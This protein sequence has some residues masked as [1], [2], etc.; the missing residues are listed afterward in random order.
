MRAQ[1]VRDP[2]LLQ[3][4]ARP[5]ELLIARC[6]QVEATDDSISDP[7]N[8]VL[9]PFSHGVATFCATSK[10]DLK[11]RLAPQFLKTNCGC[12]RVDRCVGDVAMPQ[13]VLKK[14]GVLPFVCQ[15]VP[16]TVPE[17]MRVNFDA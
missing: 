10:N 13:I 7:V 1:K 9:L 17:H 15:G 3:L 2:K 14:A 16:A 11:G 12:S 5:V 6:E 8:T 4:V